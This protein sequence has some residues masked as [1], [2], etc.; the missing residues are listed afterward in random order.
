M[1]VLVSGSGSIIAC[2]SGPCRHEIVNSGVAGRHDLIQCPL[3]A[4]CGL[5][6]RNT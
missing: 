3:E 2:G 5:A 1:M 6:R 4:V